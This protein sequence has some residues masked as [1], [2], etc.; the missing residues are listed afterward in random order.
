[1]L[2]VSQMSSNEVILTRDLDLLSHRSLTAETPFS[3]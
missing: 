2:V 1:M 3:F